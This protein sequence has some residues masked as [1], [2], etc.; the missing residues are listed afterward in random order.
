MCGRGR[1]SATPA[2]MREVARRDAG[3]PASAPW[4]HA[5]AYA[6][7]EN[8]CPGRS[9]AV[10]VAASRAKG[11]DASEPHLCTPHLCTKRW[12][13][14]ARYDASATPDFW[15]MFNARSETLHTSPV[16]RRLLR[17]RRCAV[18]LDGFFEWTDDEMKAAKATKQPW[19]VHHTSGGPLWLAGLH[20]TQSSTE[21]ETFTL[22]TMD[23][24]PK[25]SWLHDRQPVLLDAAGL[26]LWLAPP[27]TAADDEATP[28]D[29]KSSA[30]SPSKEQHDHTATLDALKRVLP[31]SELKWHATTK[32][33]SKVEYQESDASLP[34]KLPS[35]QQRSVASFFARKPGPSPTAASSSSQGAKV[36]SPPASSPS[37][38]AAAFKRGASEEKGSDVAKQPRT[39]K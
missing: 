25:L 11:D 32:K 3:V 33:M 8:L 1:Q 16:F 38:I 21:L 7:T 15:R 34:V 10:V 36:A 28:E 4:A 20:D 22:I 14:V 30:S 29:G 12:G 39:H 5:D 37:P 9:A 6:P 19:Y 35:Q 2:A 23:V 18:P 31:A 26:A 24:D 17:S 27:P 13:L